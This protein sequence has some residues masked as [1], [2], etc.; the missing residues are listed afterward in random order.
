[1]RHGVALD[2][3]GWVTAVISSEVEA[4]PG[5]VRVTAAD[6][7][8]L[9]GPDVLPVARWTDRG[10]ALPHDDRVLWRVLRS[11]GY[12]GYEAVVEARAHRHLKARWADSGAATPPPSTVTRF[13]PPD[14][15]EHEYPDVPGLRL[16]RLTADDLDASAAVGVEAGIFPARCPGDPPCCDPPEAHAWCQLA[17]R[18]DQPSTWQLALEFRG[19]PLQ[20]ELVYLDDRRPTVTWTI[21]F[22]RERPAWFWREAERPVW[23]ALRAMGHGALLSRTRANRPDWIAGLRANYGAREVGAYRA[24]TLLE[25]PLDD[26]VFRGWPAR[27]AVGATFERGGYA[28]REAQE[29]EVPALVEH[30]RGRW[31]DAPDQALYAQR[32]EDQYHLDRATLLVTERPG[33]AGKPD[34]RAV[35]FRADRGGRHLGNIALL[36]PMRQ[37]PM[38]DSLHATKAWMLAAGYS[39]ASIF[40]PTEYWESPVMQEH[41]RGAG[42]GLKVRHTKFRRPL[43]EL[44]MP[45]V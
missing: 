13:D 14:T 24:A 12:N 22:N 16:R 23:G 42:W 45:L 40:M 5:E 19:R 44:E 33:R 29:G 26:A 41:A 36:T 38:A 17:G 37:E 15:P 27:R 43:V 11:R 8:L 6:A 34:V 32:C 9:Q 18:V 31:R 25:F 2:A 30:V 10:L 3:G 35:R 20:H 1:M 7:E 4:P 21:H 39:D 28:T